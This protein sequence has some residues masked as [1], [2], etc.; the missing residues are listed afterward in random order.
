M[1]K[2]TVTEILGVYIEK[3]S[4][5]TLPAV[6]KERAKDRLL[7]ALATA[8]A[9]QALPFFKIGCE[10][11]KGSKG[12]S[13]VLTSPLRVSCR[14]AAFLNAILI[15]SIGATDTLAHAHPGGPIV[16][17]ALSVAEEVGS[18]GGDMIAAI[19]AGYETMGRVSAGSHTITPKFRGLSVF[20]PFGAAAVA[21]KLMALNAPQITNTLGYAAN[22][23]SGLTE[24]WRAG[25]MDAKFHAGMAAQNGIMAAS[26]AK[27]GATSAGTTLEGQAGFYQAFSS[28]GWDTGPVTKD[29]SSKYYIM[30]AKYKPYP[31]CYENQIP[32]SLGRQLLK[33]HNIGAAD[34]KNITVTLPIYAFLYPGVNNPGPFTSRFHKIM[35]CQ[36]C[37]A[38]VFLGMPFDLPAFYDSTDRDKEITDFIARISVAGDQKE[39]TFHLKVT[40]KNGKELI[41]QGGMD[42][43]IPTQKAV[44]EKFHS[45]SSAYLEQGKRD[46]IV[47]IVTKLD[48]LD[49][50]DLMRELRNNHS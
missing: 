33:E 4:S 9:G 21:G 22:S 32:V 27:A 43:L 8:Y 25:T 36:F 2:N 50:K 15:D 26:L 34:V 13:T 18:S 7:D 10:A 30:D 19:V 17:T 35:S 3:M 39:E 47:D 48:K 46:R 44:I 40:L 29:L 20:G 24:C 41:G 37:I 14:D 49:T 6:V 38:S 42:I 31:V 11:V 23:S 12:E 28:P 45:L 5:D 1:S 16:A